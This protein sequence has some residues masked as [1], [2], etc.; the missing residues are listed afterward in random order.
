MAI[1]TSDGETFQDRWDQLV[2][3]FPALNPASND[4]QSQANV[5]Y[6]ARDQVDKGYRFSDPNTLKSGSSFNTGWDF[7]Y[8]NAPTQAVTPGSDASTEHGIAGAKYSANVPGTLNTGIPSDVLEKLRPDLFQNQPAGG[9]QPHIE[10]GSSA[11]MIDNSHDVPYGAGASNE[12]NTVHIDRHIPRSDPNLKLP[13][14]EPADLYKYLA[15]HE[16]TEKRA[17]DVGT[18]YEQAHIGVA[19]PAERAAVEADGLNWKEYE[20]IMDGYLDHIEHENPKNP[21]PN[22]YLKPYPHNEQQILAKNAGEVPPNYS[23]NIQGA[24]PG[25][26][27]QSPFAQQVK[28]AWAA[29]QN[30]PDNAAQKFW[31]EHPFIG[32]LV[33]GLVQAMQLAGPS[34]AP[35]GTPIARPY[36]GIN[37]TGEVYPLN[38]SG[39][40][41]TF[42]S[43]PVRTTPSNLGMAILNQFGKLLGQPTE[44]QEV[45]SRSAAGLRGLEGVKNAT[46][47]E[48]SNT[49]QQPLSDTERVEAI[50]NLLKQGKVTPENLD[51]ILGTNRGE[52]IG[53]EVGKLKQQTTVPKVKQKFDMMEKGDSSS[54]E[55][56]TF[57][58]QQDLANSFN[59]DLSYGDP[60]AP[61]FK[62]GNPVMQQSSL[63]IG[64]Q[65]NAQHGALVGQGKP[66]D[67]SQANFL[68]QSWLGAQKSPVSALG[69]DPRY[70]IL[71]PNTDPKLNIGGLTDREKPYTMWT[72]TAENDPGFLTHEATHRGIDMLRE[73]N[74]MPD[75]PSYGNESL[76]RALMRRHFG[77]H[78]EAAGEASARQSKASKVVSEA[79]LDRLEDAAAKY[80]AKRKPGGPR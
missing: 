7:P 3:Q 38:P 31:Q 80:I 29:M 4:K 32:N 21:P 74:L 62:P 50:K 48:R 58:N 63:N 68:H 47:A 55:N 9:E 23:R 33:S 34:K 44:T 65:A 5:P 27:E 19:T 14:G 28:Q 37:P 53:S 17:M 70:T 57:P 52:D 72:S 1:G 8:L 60:S 13:N 69:F 22:L 64:N 15:I 24:Q 49:P 41:Y 45:A 42:P 46:E 40:T 10:A 77:T 78:E 12:G 51:Q 43:V 16:L 26:I 66:I 54:K 75:G 20:R 25:A 61:Y 39:R 79:Y 73:A 67:Q 71:S 36:A 35:G 76:V 56:D 2:S 6:T 11:I 30:P 59:T 18:P